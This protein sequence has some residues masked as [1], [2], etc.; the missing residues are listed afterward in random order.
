MLA[1]AVFPV[2]RRL[3]YG[4][5]GIC[6]SSVILLVS[7]MQLMRGQ[8]FVCNHHVFVVVVVVFCW[9]CFIIKFMLRKHL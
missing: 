2:S 3:F 6:V 8:L 4:T 1:T 5:G 9:F 7:K